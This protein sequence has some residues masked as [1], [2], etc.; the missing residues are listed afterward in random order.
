MYRFPASG[1]A[2]MLW[3]MSRIRSFRELLASAENEYCALVDSMM[4]AGEF[5]QR[6]EL[7]SKIKAMNPPLWSE[8]GG[9]FRPIPTTRARSARG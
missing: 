8:S 7:A 2:A 1:I 9:S 4:E 5:V 3:F 6:P